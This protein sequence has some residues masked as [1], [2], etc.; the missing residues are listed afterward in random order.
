MTTEQ[1]RPQTDEPIYNRG[2]PLAHTHEEVDVLVFE[3]ITRPTLNQT[4][5]EH[6]RRLQANSFRDDKIKLEVARTTI[7]E[8]FMEKSSESSSS[9]SLS[10]STSSSQRREGE[11]DRES[12]SSLSS[13]E[14]NPSRR[15]ESLFSASNIT[16][17]ADEEHDEENRVGGGYNKSTQNRSLSNILSLPAPPLLRD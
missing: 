9:T 17:Y 11:R 15:R 13:S 12:S 7:L 4:E 8:R 2:R 16:Q 6:A 14:F 10:G 1:L 3:F 5:A